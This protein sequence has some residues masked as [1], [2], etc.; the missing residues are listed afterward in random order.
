MWHV[1]FSLTYSS[2]LACLFL[3]NICRVYKE[4]TIWSVAFCW[5]RSWFVLAASSNF[6]N[7]IAYYW[8]HF[9]L[10]SDLPQ[11]TSLKIMWYLFLWH[12]LMGNCNTASAIFWYAVFWD[13]EKSCCRRGRLVYCIQTIG[14][15]PT[16]VWLLIKIVTHRNSYN[17]ANWFHCCKTT[18]FSNWCTGICFSMA[19]TFIVEWHYIDD[20][21]HLLPL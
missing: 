11:G 17:L 19:A 20:G 16:I 3:Y 4:I 7:D 10:V 12:C 6:A 9:I 18:C 13:H 1:Y 15:Y 8:L 5:C 14:I 21:M 2:F